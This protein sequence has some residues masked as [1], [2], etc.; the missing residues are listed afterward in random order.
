VPIH[1]YKCNNCGRVNELMVGIGRNSDELVCGGCGGSQL[2]ILMSAPANTNAGTSSNQTCCGTSP[3]N[4][5]CVPGS[6]CG[7]N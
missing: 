7:S 1:E 4:K 5:G 2:E 3:G 6:C